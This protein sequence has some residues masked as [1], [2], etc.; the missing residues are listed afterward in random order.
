MAMLRRSPA[1]AALIGLVVLAL[2]GFGVFR[3]VSRV[4]N[5]VNDIGSDSSTGGA[6]GDSLY[7]AEN[8][9]TALNAVKAKVGPGGDILEIRVEA[10]QAKFTVR[11]GKSESATGYTAK[12]GDGGSLSTF[13]VDVVGQGSLNN[14]AIPASDV[15]APALARMEA[16]ALK[17]DPKAKLDTIQFFTLDVDT[18]T[19]KPEWN[20]NVHGQLYLA[21]LSGAGLHSPGEGAGTLSNPDLSPAAKLGLQL[22]HCI[23]QAKG[24]VA[25]ITRCQHKFVPTP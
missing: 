9:A 24:D 8:F 14:S 10:K 5:N 4:T 17:R 19:R 25:K 13:N 1:G 6:D 20:M 12:A 11:N 23:A 18:G 16:A 22:S 21:K 3:L 7:R 15:T 2:V